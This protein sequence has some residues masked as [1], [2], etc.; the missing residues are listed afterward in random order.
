MNDNVGRGDDA[1]DASILHV[2]LDAFY[3]SV[4]QLLEPSLRGRPVIV[5]GIARRGVVCAASYEA[6]ASGVHSAMPTAQARRRCPDAVF[7]TPRMSVYGEFSERVMAILHEITPLVEQL[8]IDEAFLDVGGSRRTL[9][10]GRAAAA[11]VRARVRDEV[12]LTASVGVATTKFLAKVASDKAKPDGLLV[13]DPG[14]EIEFL[15]PLPVRALWGVG[16]KT[17]T[18]LE[19]FGVTSVGD[20]ARL[21]LE[22]LVSALGSTAGTHLHDL[23]RNDDPRPVVTDREVKSIG[24]EE[25]FG[26]DLDDRADIER[27]LLRLA[28]SVAARLRAAHVRARTINL[29]ARYPD[30]STVTR[31]RTLDRPT[32]AAPTIMA[33]VRTLLDQIDHRRGLRLVGIHCSSLCAD[34]QPV[35]ETFAFVETGSEPIDAQRR[36][37]DIDRTVDDVRRRFGKNAV[38]PAALLRGEDRPNPPMRP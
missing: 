9:G 29:K 18:K 3:A 20:V 6:R 30:F 13:I 16:P 17:A 4:E 27:E 37:A 12:G 31:A 34:D 24:H 2:D 21:P 11:H 23:S 38:R 25:T 32:D 5:G 15:H 35:Q 22:I 26:D 14:R 28:D 19:R 8:S 33:T 1:V 7:L 36:Q 10:D